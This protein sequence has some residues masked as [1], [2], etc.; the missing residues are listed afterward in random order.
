VIRSIITLGRLG[1]DSRQEWVKSFR[2]KYSQDDLNWNKYKDT[3]GEILVNVYLSSTMTNS[4]KLYM[5]IIFNIY[6]LLFV[7][8]SE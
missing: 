6:S 8:S 4:Y 3:N 2:L 5:Y 1:N 7:N